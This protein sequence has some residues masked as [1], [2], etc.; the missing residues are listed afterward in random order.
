M[1]NP[2]VDYLRENPELKVSNMTLKHRL[3]L[4]RSR[5]RHFIYYAFRDNLIRKVAPLEVGSNRHIKNVFIY[6]Y[7]DSS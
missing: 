6:Q 1:Q 7:N 4:N 3:K 2:V 5:I